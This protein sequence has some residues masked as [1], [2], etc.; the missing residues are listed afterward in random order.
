MKTTWTVTT[1]SGSTYSVTQENGEWSLTGK[2]KPNEFSKEWPEGHVVRIQPPDRY[3]WLPWPPQIN[4]VL[5]FDAINPDDQVMR[6]GYIRTS[7]I[8]G[9]EIK[10]C[11]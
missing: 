9:L 1:K 7:R 10:V 2:N 8:V 5:V 6:Q 11:K 4:G 3:A